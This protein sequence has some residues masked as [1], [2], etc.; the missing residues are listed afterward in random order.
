MAIERRGIQFT[1]TAENRARGAFSEVQRQ[2]TEIGAASNA[3]RNTLA[4]LGVGLSLG[5][6]VS[7]VKGGIDAAAQLDDLA[8][9]TG[10]SVE[11]LSKL[12]QVARISGT[13]FGVVES[14]LVKLNKALHTNAE[15]GKN[16]RAALQA[17]GLS[18]EELRKL[19]PAEAMRRVAVELTRFADSGGKTAAVLALTGKS[20]AQSL[21]FLKD[22]ATETGIVARTTAEQAAAAEEL[23]KQIRRLSNEVTV[24]GQALAQDLVPALRTTVAAMHEAYEEGGLL[25]AV[26][27]GLTTLSPMFGD[28]AKYNREFVQLTDE[29]LASQNERARRTGLGQDAEV[30]ALDEYIKSLQE[31]LKIVGDMRRVLS[32]EMDVLGNPT[33][34]TPEKPK[35]KLDSETPGTP[36]KRFENALKQ[37]EQ[38]AIKVQELTRFEEVLA[39]VEA[40]RYGKLSADQ[41]QVLTNLA[42]QVDLSKIDAQTQKEVATALEAANK[43]SEALA[44]SEGERL[45]RLIDKYEELIDPLKRY[46]DQL[47]EIDE[48]ER[49]GFDPEKVRAAR[50]RVNRDMIEATRNLYDFKQETQDTLDEMTEFSKQ[51]ARNIHDTFAENLFSLMQGDFDNLGSRF[52]AMLDRMVA[53]ALAARLS[54]AV[55]GK[56]F[57]RS[58]TFTSSGLIGQALNFLGLGVKTTSSMA[59][60][61]GVPEIIP[62]DLF[63]GFAQGGSFRVGGSG[64]TDS[65]LVAFRA[66]PDERVTIQTPAQQLA[67]GMG[68]TTIIMNVYAQDVRGF[69]ESEGQIA[70]SLMSRLGG[71]ARRYS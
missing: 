16:A 49:K 50:E 70:A 3:L 29:L 61:T 33:P 22:L 43:A 71:R 57:G 5:G 11:E 68:T 35:K 6:L 39:D 53:D 69:R 62:L 24:A 4:G 28:L 48:L 36:D 45:T 47:L 60:M 25:K 30:K 66:S 7:F 12:T 55:F 20:A 15:E 42:A 27:T 2:M 59:S 52:K 17:I 21:P 58:G 9:I 1:L 64:G 19:D 67:G 51:A 44:R 14:F 38:E 63:G 18:A 37:L 23:Q 46:K 10:A 8:E 31:R 41:R 13:E 40:G 32:G 54:E 56:D 34:K 26:F 65:Q